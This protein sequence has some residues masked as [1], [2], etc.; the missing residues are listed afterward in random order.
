MGRC[1]LLN[2]VD[3]CNLSISVQ[4]D[5][6]RGPPEYSTSVVEGHGVNTKYSGA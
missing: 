6:C 5:L 3:L 4:L 1:V 2:N